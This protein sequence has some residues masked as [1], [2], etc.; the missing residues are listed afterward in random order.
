MAIPRKTASIKK[1]STTETSIIAIRIMK[2]I[3]TMR[4]YL[5]ADQSL[6]FLYFLIQLFMV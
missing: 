2:R 5:L 6:V 3:A 1:Q 4:L